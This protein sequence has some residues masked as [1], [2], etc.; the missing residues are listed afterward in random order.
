[1]LK[2]IGMISAQLVLIGEESNLSG[3][4]FLLAAFFSFLFFLYDH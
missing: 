1:M 3:L 2:N 4:T